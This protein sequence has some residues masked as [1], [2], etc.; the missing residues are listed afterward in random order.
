MEAENTEQITD[1]VKVFL[2]YLSAGLCFLWAARYCARRGRP[3]PVSRPPA[4]RGNAAPA[5]SS[6]SQTPPDTRGKSAHS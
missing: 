6:A 1:Y 3:R 5:P 2:A 4:A